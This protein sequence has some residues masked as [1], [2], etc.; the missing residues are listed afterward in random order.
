MGANK[1]GPEKHDADEASKDR[2]ATGNPTAT[3]GFPRLHELAEE[4]NIAGADTMTRAEV[5]QELTDAL[6]PEELKE[7]LDDRMTPEEL[8]ASVKE[9]GPKP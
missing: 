2:D 3:K 7:G 9:K 8:L 6:S 1:E 5:A 4:E